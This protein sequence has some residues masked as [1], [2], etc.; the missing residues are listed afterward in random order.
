MACT[1]VTGS[2]KQSTLTAFLRATLASVMLPEART[3]PG[4]SSSLTLE[5][6]WTSCI[7][8]VNPGTPPTP[9]ARLRFRELIRDDLPTSGKTMQLLKVQEEMEMEWET[10]KM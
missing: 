8:R 6:S 1:G 9:H 5:S 2:S 4:E 3:I 10:C 7:T